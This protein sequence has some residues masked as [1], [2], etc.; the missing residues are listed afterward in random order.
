MSRLGAGSYASAP[1]R[2]IFSCS[3]STYKCGG[4]LLLFVYPLETLIDLPRHVSS[5]T[6]DVEPASDRIVARFDSEKVGPG[7]VRLRRP[8]DLQRGHR[9]SNEPTLRRDL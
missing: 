8:G 5:E 6:P 4:M 3:A 1:S 7:R 9:L 2:S